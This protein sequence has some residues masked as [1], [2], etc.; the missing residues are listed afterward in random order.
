MIKN[1]II[2]TLAVATISISAL[3]WTGTQDL[4]NVKADAQ[5]MHET[6]SQV[7]TSLVDMVKRYKDV[8]KENTSLK[9]ELE[10]A[11]ASITQ[12]NKETKD[13]ATIV[14]FQMKAADMNRDQAM[15]EYWHADDVK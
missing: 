3:A 6:T 12:A 11:N 2:S 4:E 8:K 13:T 1:A 15:H 10:K 14:H 7:S 9:A 5:H